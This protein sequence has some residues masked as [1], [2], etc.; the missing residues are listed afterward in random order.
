MK[1]VVGQNSIVKAKISRFTRGYVTDCFE[2]LNDDVCG[3]MSGGRG[4]Q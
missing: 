3:V 1:L 4:F 2:V